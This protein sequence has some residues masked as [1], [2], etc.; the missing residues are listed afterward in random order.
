[1]A[2]LGFVGFVAVGFTIVGLVG[3]GCV[4]I[5][6]GRYTGHKITKKYTKKNGMFCHFQIYNIRVLAALQWANVQ[7]EKYQANINLIR[8]SIE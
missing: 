8:F 7:L 4:G 2:C 3:G 5:C 1:M 6:I